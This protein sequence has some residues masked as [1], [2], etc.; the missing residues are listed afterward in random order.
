M[1]ADTHNLVWCGKARLSGETRRSA[2]DQ[3]T[4]LGSASQL[5]GSLLH[6]PLSRRL[7]V[8]FPFRSFR[9]TFE[10][11]ELLDPDS[12]VV[13]NSYFFRQKGINVRLKRRSVIPAKDFAS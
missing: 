11:F 4:C 5:R 6:L 9:L 13:E 8:I 7:P 12:Y 2:G 1:D 3:E 10:Q